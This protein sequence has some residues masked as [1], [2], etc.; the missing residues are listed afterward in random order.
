MSLRARYSSDLGWDRARGAYSAMIN[1]FDPFGD[2]HGVGIVD[3]RP[4]FTAD[5]LGAVDSGGTAI[6]SGPSD[7]IELRV[8]VERLTGPGTWPV[9]ELPAGFVVVETRNGEVELDRPAAALGLIMAM[10]SRIEDRSRAWRTW[11]TVV[12]SLAAGIPPSTKLTV[13]SLLVIRS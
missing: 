2:S 5:E 6:V 13:E 7:L 12:E 4:G 10:E 9:S 8:L 11:K 1:G 3:L